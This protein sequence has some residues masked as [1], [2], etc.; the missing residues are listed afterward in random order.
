MQLEEFRKRRL[1]GGTTGSEGAGVPIKNDEAAASQGLV[2]T[3]D[4]SSIVDVEQR[5]PDFFPQVGVSDS[6]VVG[7]GQQQNVV[8]QDEL[9]KKGAA[10]EHDMQ[11]A[12][13]EVVAV[14]QVIE[15][16][17]DSAQQQQHVQ[18]DMVQ[19]EVM[20]Q[21]PEILQTDISFGPIAS[22]SK[23]R[24]SEKNIDPKNFIVACP[25]GS[26]Q[27]HEA[28]RITATD[29]SLLVPPS[30]PSMRMDD[31]TNQR[32]SVVGEVEKKHGSS[33]HE[34]IEEKEMPSQIRDGE[35][36]LTRR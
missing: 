32:G 6:N 25:D 23:Q 26:R 34:A 5:V 15:N 17:S 20:P 7:L 19:V 36:F 18:P 14:S 4:K 27:A 29:E 35:S 2:E 1:N 28:A 31:V 30:A 12:D 10:I 21:E 24:V 16:E 11:V 8:Q 9:V 33:Y 3:T 13:N 22:Q